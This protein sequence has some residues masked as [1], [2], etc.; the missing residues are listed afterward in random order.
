MKPRHES[1]LFQGGAAVTKLKLQSVYTAATPSSERREKH[2]FSLRIRIPSL[3][4]A[5]KIQWLENT[6]GKTTNSDRVVRSPATEPTEPF[7]KLRAL[8]LS[9]RLRYR[10]H[11]A[12]HAVYSVTT[13]AKKSA[14]V[15]ALISVRFVYDCDDS[16]FL[17]PLHPS[18]S[19]TCGE[20]SIIRAISTA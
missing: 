15:I 14:G 10:V 17:F 2:L 3:C 8:S 16:I 18:L 1:Q 19:R 13:V 11:R 7:D 20:G 5:K 6:R 9:K 4:G 12:K